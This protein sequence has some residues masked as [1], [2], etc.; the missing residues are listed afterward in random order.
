M[1]HTIA[2]ADEALDMVFKNWPV[3]S[4]SAFF[5]AMEARAR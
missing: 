5:M 3:T 1:R 2:S 4:G